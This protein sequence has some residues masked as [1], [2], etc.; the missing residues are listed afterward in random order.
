MSVETAGADRAYARTS[1]RLASENTIRAATLAPST[2][3]DPA[4]W[5]ARE[6]VSGRNA[7]SRA[8]GSEDAV[9]A[10]APIPSSV[11]RAPQ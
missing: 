4:T 3:I 8:S 6:R 10:V 2:L 1:E 11:T 7:I 5:V 9:G